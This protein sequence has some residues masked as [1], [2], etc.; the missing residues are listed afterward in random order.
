VA[1][2]KAGRAR[3]RNRLLLSALTDSAI[4][5]SF[6]GTDRTLVWRGKPE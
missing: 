1:A 2:R 5:T 4:A 3:L 6:R